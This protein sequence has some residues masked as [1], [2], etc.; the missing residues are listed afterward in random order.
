VA[1]LRIAA[2]A[3]WLTD[4]LTGAVVGSAFGVGVPVLEKRLV[5]GVRI[6]PAPGGIA[7]RF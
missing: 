6:A 5:L 7:I 3:H 2:D 1:H 4:V